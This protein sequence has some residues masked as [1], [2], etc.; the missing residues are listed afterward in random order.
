MEEVS[1][2]RTF[3]RSPHDIRSGITDPLRKIRQARAIIFRDL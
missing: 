1:R 3:G 2:E